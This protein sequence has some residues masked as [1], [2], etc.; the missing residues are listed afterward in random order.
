[1]AR[2]MGVVIEKLCESLEPYLTPSEGKK[3]KTPNQWM[4]CNLDYHPSPHITVRL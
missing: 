2:L 3:A 4:I 1:M